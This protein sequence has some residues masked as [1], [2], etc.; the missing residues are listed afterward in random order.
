[1][2]AVFNHSVEQSY[3]HISTPRFVADTCPPLKGKPFARAIRIHFRN[4]R[5]KRESTSKW[6]ILYACW[7]IG[8]VNVDFV[9]P[10]C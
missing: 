1:M 4:R 8:G 5:R 3:L 7:S 10:K 9:Q 2:W 6:C